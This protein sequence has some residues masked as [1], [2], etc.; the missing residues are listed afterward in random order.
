MIVVDT[1]VMVHL[2][3]GAGT[4]YGVGPGAGPDAEQEK[5]AIAATPPMTSPGEAAARLLLRD[6]EWAAPTILL[7]ELRNV[8][9]GLLRRGDL[10][11]SD[12]SAICDDA[13]AILGDR[14]VSVPS[15]AVLAVAV[16]AGLSAYDAEFVVLARR[17]GLSLIT[18]D[19]AILDGAPD[20]AVP[21]MA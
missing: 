15:S 19:G 3:T 8:L 1:N 16:E 9:I 11:S 18:G 12:A 4:A 6:P 5:S 20:V 7:S 10:G 13:E 14:M 21:L 2:L 17:L